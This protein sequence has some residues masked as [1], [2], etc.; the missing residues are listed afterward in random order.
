MCVGLEARLRLAQGRVADA[1]KL[2]DAMAGI[3]AALGDAGA[4]YAPEVQRLRTEL[5][6]AAG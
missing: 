2:A 3:L 5:A 4:P 6:G 1:R